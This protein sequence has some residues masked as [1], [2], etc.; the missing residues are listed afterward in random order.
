MRVDHTRR[1]AEVMKFYAGEE[2]SKG[3]L[4]L[5]AEVDILGQISLRTPNPITAMEPQEIRELAA[6]LHDLSQRA[7]R[8]AEDE[9]HLRA[10]S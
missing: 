7:C 4:V 5:T 6:K 1:V 2:G 10:A 9:E 3:V 8:L